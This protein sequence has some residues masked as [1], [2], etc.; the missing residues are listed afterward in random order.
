MSQYFVIILTVSLL[1]VSCEHTDSKQKSGIDN[2]PDTKAGEVVRKAIDFAGGWEAW[3]SKKNLSFYKNITQV[4]STGEIIKHVRQLHRYNLGDQFKAN[5]TWSVDSVNY[6][7]INDG[8]EARKYENG[9][10]LTDKKSKNEAWNSS[11]GSHYVFGM[12]YK[13]TDPGVT[14][15]YEG[16]DEKVLS[17]PVHSVKVEYAEDAGSSGGMHTWWYYFDKN[18]YDLAGFFLDYGN[19]YSL[20]TYET[21]LQVGEHRIHNKRFSYASNAKQE[22]V[23]LKTIYGNEEIKFDSEFD[24]DLFQLK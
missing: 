3:K 13:L 20:T 17:K 1:F 12:P 15:S 8:Q 19:G 2:L 5:M 7:I 23:Q 24:S 11:F 9:K 14:L 22:K 6:L 4:D 16:I 10:E 21:F 18:N